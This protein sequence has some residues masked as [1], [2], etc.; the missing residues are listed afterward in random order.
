MHVD[1]QFLF[2]NSYDLLTQSSV[3]GMFLM[4]TG[5]YFFLWAKRKED[6]A[7][8]VGD[9]DKDED[10]LESERGIEKPLLS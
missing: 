1:I 2:K 7:I 9:R 4:F 5:L 8:R 6:F 10:G 3:A